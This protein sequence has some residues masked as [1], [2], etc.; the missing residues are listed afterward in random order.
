MPCKLIK[1][2]AKSYF[3]CSHEDRAK[4]LNG[5]LLIV[6]IFHQKK[7]KKYMIARSCYIE[8]YIF[9]LELV[10]ILYRKPQKNNIN[11]ALLGK[12]FTYRLLIKELSISKYIVSCLMHQFSNFFD[13]VMPF[14]EVFWAQFL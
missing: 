13:M 5:L 11:N 4:Y 10:C 12:S 3:C 9:A 1:L 2:H 6:V 8:K 7:R 14:L